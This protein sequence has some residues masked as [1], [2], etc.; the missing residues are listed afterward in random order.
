M[1]RLRLARKK[2]VEYCQTC[3]MERLSVFPCTSLMNSVSSIK[4]YLYL[5]L[6]ENSLR[7]H[8][9]QTMKSKPNYSQII[10]HKL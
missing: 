8:L 9:R 6:E 10:V 5:N 3:L 1:A 2:D 4:G 7:F